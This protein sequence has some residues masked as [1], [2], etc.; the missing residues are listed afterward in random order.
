MFSLP[1]AV[2]TLHLADDFNRPGPSGTVPYWTVVD[3]DRTVAEW[4]ANG[5]SAHRRPKTITTG[6]RLC[7]L[8]D[9]FGNLFGIRQAPE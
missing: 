3:V 1:G 8:H 5:A 9:P 2:L 7:Q 6:E 4:V